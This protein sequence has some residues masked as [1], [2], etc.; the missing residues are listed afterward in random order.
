M[1]RLAGTVFAAV[2]IVLIGACS[3]GTQPFVVGAVNPSNHGGVILDLVTAELSG[4]GDTDGASYRV[5]FDGQTRDA[6]ALRGQAE[7][8]VAAEVDALLAFTQ[9]AVDIALE[10]RGDADIPIVAWTL[11]E[12]SAVRVDPETGVSAL[13][14]TGVLPGFSETPAE[15]ERLAWMKRLVPGVRAV[16]VPYNPNDIDLVQGMEQFRDVA[17]RVGMDLLL[18]PVRTP[19]EAAAAASSVPDAADGVFLFGDRAIGSARASF[20]EY[21]RENGLPLSGP[22]ISSVR[23]GALYAYSFT[24]E[25]VAR[26]MARQVR[27]LRDGTPVEQMPFEVPEFTLAVNLE[28]ARAID[29]EIPDEVLAQAGVIVR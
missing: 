7:D 18:E 11:D 10:A 5:R 2:S 13:S 23:D 17:D 3:T 28:T 8:L 20:Y 16:Y 22:N 26:I 9:F 21:A 6:E 15:E 1:F 4:N 19:E 24:S 12:P 25:S 14:M 29:V 27:S